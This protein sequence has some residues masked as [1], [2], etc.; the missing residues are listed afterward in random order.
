[1][2]N[3]QDYTNSLAIWQRIRDALSGQ[4]AIIAGTT[5]YLPQLP[6]QDDDEY[7]AYQQRALYFNKTKDTLNILTGLAMRKPGVEDIP[8]SMSDFIEDVNRAGK[9]L[10]ELTK[11]TLK[12]TIAMYRY[13]LLVEYPVIDRTKIK[14]VLDAERAGLKPYISEYRA[15]NIINWHSENGFLS[16]VV[17]KEY[18]TERDQDDEFK[19]IDKEQY[20]VLELVDGVY[21]QR[22]FRNERQYGETITPRMNGQT[23]SQIPFRIVGGIE[24]EI[25]PI[26]DLV[27]VN[28]KHFAVT[29]D[30]YHGLHFAN[31]P[32][33][34]GAGFA[35]DGEIKIG[36]EN[37]I[38]TANPDAKLDWKSAGAEGAEPSRKALE[39]LE[40]RMAELGAQIIS[41]GSNRT[42]TEADIVNNSQT[43]SLVNIVIEVSKS[44]SWVLGM[45][46]QWM[47]GGGDLVFE[48]NTDFNVNKIDPQ[49]IAQLLAATTSGNMSQD[50]FIEA[51]IEGEIIK[52]RDVETEKELIEVSFSDLTGE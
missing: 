38:F 6:G 28:L 41:S 47:N 3:K 9:T 31:V 8:E 16:L 44:I 39:D 42:A 7:S 32:V 25:P 1:M 37:G 40:K 34:F 27:N 35:A 15:E 20:R 2:H 30:Y 52:K 21:Q 43:A 46:N 26:L 10:E 48:M 29:A 19:Y 17:L 18:Y 49:M 51:L 36:S 24:P 50:S 33:L 12:E 22:V 14:T 13:G 4:D 45:V 11:I 23:L 5:D